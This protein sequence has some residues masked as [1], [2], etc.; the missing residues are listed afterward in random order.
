MR[1]RGRSRLR[2]QVPGRAALR[3]N[4][5]AR[6]PILARLLRVNG[7]ESKDQRHDQS[8]SFC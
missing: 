6:V 4:L 2:M 7:Q 1:Q 3:R 5:L 8:Q